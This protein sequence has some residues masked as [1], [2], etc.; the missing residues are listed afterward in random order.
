MKPTL[1]KFAPSLIHKVLHQYPWYMF[2]IIDFRYTFK[3]Y[4]VN[5]LDFYGIWNYECPICHSKHRWERHGTYPRF[6]IFPEDGLFREESMDILRLRCTSCRHTHAILPTDVIPYCIYSVSAILSVCSASLTA[7]QAVL[8][9]VPLHGL[10]YQVVY[11]MLRLLGL[12]LDRICLLLR[13][14]CLWTAAQNP[15]PAE[16]LAYF[17]PSF[18][19]AFALH[20]RNPVFLKRRSTGTYP[21]YFGFRNPHIHSPT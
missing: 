1:V 4:S 5:I 2:M 14:L 21:L 13:D 17:D 19:A 7:N 10:C 9:L 20:F 12:Y 16:F 15:S 11:S 8:E 3:T 18:C 6:L